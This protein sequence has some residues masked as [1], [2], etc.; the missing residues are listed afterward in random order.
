M[1]MKYVKLS[2]VGTGLPALLFSVACAPVANDKTISQAPIAAYIAGQ[3]QVREMEKEVEHAAPDREADKKPAGT[4]AELESQ[5]VLV[6]SEQYLPQQSYDELG[7]K[8][9]YQAAPSPYREVTQSVPAGDVNDFVAARRAYRSEDYKKADKLL[10]D[11]SIRSPHLSGPYALRAQ[12]ALQ[13]QEKAQALN[14]YKKAISINPENVNVYIGM[15]NLQRE[16]GEFK[17]AQNTY[18]KAL[19]V[20]K[21]FPEAHANLAILYDIY[22]NKPLDAQKH[23]EAFHFLT[24]GSDRRSEQWLA[25]IQQRTGVDTSFVDAPS[26]TAAVASSTAAD[27]QVTLV[28]REGVQ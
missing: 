28:D 27:R 16:L 23:M 12:I 9:P 19:S 14:Y 11:L 8:V 26:S 15:A 4:E 13:D 3:D 25:E 22:L 2:A 17:Q 1:S 24:Q 7:E 10:R 5:A 21:D 6:P 18:V 20:W